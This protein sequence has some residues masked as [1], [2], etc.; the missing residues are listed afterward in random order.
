LNLLEENKTLIPSI[1]LIKKIIYN[2]P[3]FEH[4]ETLNSLHSPPS[5]PQSGY[6]NVHQSIAE[7]NY[8]LRE[9]QSEQSS[10]CNIIRDAESELKTDTKRISSEEEDKDV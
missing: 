3:L 2:M 8:C 4:L 6:R 5:T 9:A 1:Q 7:E 10:I